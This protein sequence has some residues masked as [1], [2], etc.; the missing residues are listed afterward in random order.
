MLS[1][2]T[3][4]CSQPSEVKCNISANGFDGE[5]EGCAALV[6]D[7]VDDD[8]DDE[9]EKV[10]EAVPFIVKSAARVSSACGT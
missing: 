6:E 9:E 5:E 2:S 1:G 8:G 3:T 4:G 10:A 7:V